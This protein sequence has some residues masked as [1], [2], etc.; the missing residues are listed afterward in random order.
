[1]QTFEFSILGDP[2]AV[3]GAGESRNGEKKSAWES[4]TGEEAPGNQP[5]PD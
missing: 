3:S 2:G 5:L 4:D 1:M